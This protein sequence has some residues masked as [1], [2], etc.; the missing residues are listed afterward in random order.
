MES[1]RRAAMAADAGYFK[2]QITPVQVPARKGTCW[3]TGQF[4]ERHGL[5]PLGRLP[6]R[7]EA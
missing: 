7:P 1:H 3:P 4:T 2:E 5:R 6:G